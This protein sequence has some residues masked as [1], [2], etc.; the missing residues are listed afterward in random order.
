[1]LIGSFL[2][3]K[4][5]ADLIA[6]VT[7]QAKWQKSDLSQLPPIRRGLECEAWFYEAM[8]ARAHGDRSRM[9]ESLRHCEQTRVK[10]YWEYD[11]SVFL[12]AHPD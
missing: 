9:L 6:T 3:K 1:M 10:G 2:E 7:D 11:M 12:L 4:E 8:R 5:S